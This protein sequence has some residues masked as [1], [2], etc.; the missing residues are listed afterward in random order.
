[1][2]RDPEKTFAM[3]LHDELTKFLRFLVLCFCMEVENPFVLFG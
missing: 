2:N 1:M 3:T